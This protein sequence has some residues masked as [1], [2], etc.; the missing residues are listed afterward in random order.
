[1]KTAKELADAIAAT[2][3]TDSEIAIRC[4][5]SQPTI[6]RIR[7]DKIEDC[8]GSLYA[9]LLKLYSEQQEAA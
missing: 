1:M 5:T 4:K 6:W 3:M 7:N 2:G 9:A 8:R